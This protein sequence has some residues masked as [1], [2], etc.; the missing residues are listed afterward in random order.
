MKYIKN[1]EH[2]LWIEDQ[3]FIELEKMNW[4][5]QLIL[6]IYT[7]KTKSLKISK[8][9]TNYTNC[10]IVFHYIQ[11]SV[12]ITNHVY[13]KAIY[14]DFMWRHSLPHW[15]LAHPCKPTGALYLMLLLH[16]CSTIVYYCGCPCLLVMMLL[17][18][19]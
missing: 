15:F 5:K 4:Y 1:L 6:Y 3:S 8:S 12:I 9:V 13:S 16:V 10:T 2:S 18:L 19:Y 11:D 14:E 17:C 7:S